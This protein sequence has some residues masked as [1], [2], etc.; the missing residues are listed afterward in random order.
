MTPAPSYYKLTMMT[1]AWP[2][3]KKSCQATVALRESLSTDPDGA[4]LNAA[5]SRW[6]SIW[7]PVLMKFAVIGLNLP[8]NT[9]E[10]RLA[11]HI[12]VIEIERRPNPPSHAK[13]FK[14]RHGA[15]MTNDEWAEA[16]TRSLATEQQVEDWRRDQRGND[17]VRIVV[18]CEDLLRFLFFSFRD[19]GRSEREKDRE[20][21]RQLGMLWVTALRMKIEAGDFAME[22]SELQQ[23]ASSRRNSKRIESL[24]QATTGTVIFYTSKSALRPAQCRSGAPG[25]SEGVVKTMSG[26]ALSTLLHPFISPSQH[27]RGDL[28]CVCFGCFMDRD[29]TLWWDLLRRY[30]EILPDDYAGLYLLLFTIS[31]YILLYRRPNK[32]H[33]ATSIAMFVLT[34]AYVGIDFTKAIITPTV[35]SSSYWSAGNIMPCVDETPVRRN[36]DLLSAL[37]QPIED[38]VFAL[39]M[40]GDLRPLSRDSALTRC[41][42]ADS[43]PMGY[44]CVASELQ[45][46]RPNGTLDFPLLSHMASSAVGN[47]SISRVATCHDGYVAPRNPQNRPPISPSC[48]ACNF[49]VITY[50]FKMYHLR[51]GLSSI[52]TNPPQRWVEL[53]HLGD[54]FAVA[55]YSLSLATNIFTTI[56]IAFPIW[57]M[58]RELEKVLGSV[59]RAASEKY[60]DAISMVVESGALYSCS[61]LI[62]LLVIA[63]SK[64]HA[65][66][67]SALNSQNII[68]CANNILVS[69]APTLII[70]RVAMS[71]DFATTQSETLHRN[72]ITRSLLPASGPM[73]FAENERDGINAGAIETYALRSPVA[74]M[75][76][77][78]HPSEGDMY[79]ALSRSE[80][81][82]ESSGPSSAGSERP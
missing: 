71:K 29:A 64:N 52:T 56:L 43:L 31:I 10:D 60:R 39:N 13:F 77:V 2:T 23:V 41:V 5:L 9:A 45:F 47:H 4:A 82:V 80:S 34:T 40:Y 22:D 50:E 3:H 62:N 48:V 21:A 69:I 55:A 32:Y 70:V 59:G 79:D 78:K 72:N 46:D 76:R 7:R 73:R 74:V 44:W 26:L 63:T 12:V 16:M 38:I 51:Q 67:L 58:S 28:L 49:V 75:Q 14:L 53:G 65:V 11:T 18:A 30:M 81:S 36:E 66:R 68:G 54:R 35:T 1:K 33:F 57:Q 19:G 8:N 25:A 61:L 6:I 24:Y 20:I 17:T 27:V 37:L 42:V 15:V